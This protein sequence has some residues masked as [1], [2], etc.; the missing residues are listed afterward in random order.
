MPRHPLAVSLWFADEVAGK[1]RDV[2]AQ[3]GFDQVKDLIIEE[4]PKEFRMGEVRDVHCFRTKFRGQRI[5]QRLEV[6]LQ[7]GELILGEDLVAIDEVTFALVS[8][9]LFVGQ[10]WLE[11]CRH[12]FKESMKSLAFRPLR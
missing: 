10:S 2:G 1:E 6:G 7:S 4:P 8:L 11:S 5:E 3:D 9:G 12:G